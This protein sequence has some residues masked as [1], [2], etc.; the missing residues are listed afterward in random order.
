MSTKAYYKT[1]A[2]EVMAALEQR[3]QE[4]KAIRE[5]GDKF[6]E[7]FGG[8]MLVE[9][10]T[11]HGYSVAGLFFTPAKDRRLWIV[12]EKDACNRQRPRKSAPGLTPEEKATLK[13]LN[14]DWTALFPKDVAKLRPVLDACGTKEDFF[15]GHTFGMF[16][17]GGHLYVTTTV[18]VAPHMTE[19]LGSEYSAARA[20]FAQETEAKKTAAPVAA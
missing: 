13:Q 19:I 8:T 18:A 15:F 20:M 16:E 1:N 3:H 10:S 4:M 12:P 17:H 5:A 6:A 9:N 14:E 7:H 11:Y 2:P